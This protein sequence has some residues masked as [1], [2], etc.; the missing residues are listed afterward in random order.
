MHRVV[1]NND[2][3]LGELRASVE[4]HLRFLQ[5][6]NTKKLD[7]MRQTVDEKL[8]GT[9]EKRLGESFKLVSQQLEQVHKGLGDMQ[10]LAVG[11]GDLKR[12]L[13]NVKTRGTW[14]EILLGQVL[15]PE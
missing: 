4:H 11:V 5:Q 6:E 1:E 9:L 2:K 12:V 14:G 3:R 10:N 8:Q 13:G 15:A 7:E